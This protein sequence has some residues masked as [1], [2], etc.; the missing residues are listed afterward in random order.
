MEHTQMRVSHPVLF[1][2]SK[3][4]LVIIGDA[5]SASLI[6]QALEVSCCNLFAEMCSA[7]QNIGKWPSLY[8]G[9]KT[10]SVFY[11]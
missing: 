11:K 7:S 4:I 1:K 2:T 6:L 5:T 10:S 8:S 9:R 3:K